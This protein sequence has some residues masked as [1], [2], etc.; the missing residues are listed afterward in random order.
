MN[1]LSKQTVRGVRPMIFFSY[2][3]NRPKLALR[4]RLM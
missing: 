4:W 1:L 2:P 3:K